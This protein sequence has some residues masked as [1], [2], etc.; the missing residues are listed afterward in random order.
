MPAMTTARTGTGSSLLL[1]LSFFFLPTAHAGTSGVFSGLDDIKF[2]SGSGTNRAALLIQWNDGGTPSSLVWGFR[3]NG[4]ATGIDMIRAVA[5]SS[6]IRNP[7]GALLSSTNGS[8]PRLSTVWT[9]YNFGDA[10]DA[11]SW[12][13]G[14]TS[15]GKVDWNAGYWQYSIYGGRLEYDQYDENGQVIGS[16]TYD[17]SGSSLYPGTSW[18]S[19]PVG[20][21]D[22]PL[23]NEAWDAWSFAAGFV[24]VSIVSPQPASIPAPVVKSIRFLSPTQLEIVFQTAP[25][26]SYQLE[27][28]MDLQGSDWA[29]RGTTLVASGPETV[30]TVTT[31][32][33]NLREFYR[34][35]QIP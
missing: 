24:P 5:G 12:K 20:A 10:L 15:R 18:F 17:Q 11:V 29:S 21:G 3:W 4:T 33:Q 6:E 1:F 34:L 25:N 9:A 22:R 30:L 32:P 31:Q 2:W 26:V 19:S 23:V 7:A 8:D 13:S 14:G 27:S 35:K 16:A 28:T